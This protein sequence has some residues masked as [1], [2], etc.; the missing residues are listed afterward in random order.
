MLVSAAVS[1]AYDQE[2]DRVNLSVKERERERDCGRSERA[3]E[4]ET[5]WK[6]L[7]IVSALHGSGVCN[8]SNACVIRDTVEWALVE[9]KVVFSDT[10]TRYVSESCHF[11]IYIYIYSVA[12]ELIN[13]KLLDIIRQLMYTENVEQ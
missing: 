9:R 12:G 11:Y 7:L 1:A 6:N 3:T 4:N 10:L 5:N 13:T 8:P 2:K